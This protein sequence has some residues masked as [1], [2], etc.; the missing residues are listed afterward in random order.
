MLG[1]ELF[2]KIVLAVI[3]SGLIGLEREVKERPAG[4]RTHILVCLGAAL[5]TL[6]SV[7]YFPTTSDSAARII[8][9]IITG[10]GFLGA[11]TIINSDHHV[12]GLTTAAGVWVVAGLG[13]ILGL[14]YYYLALVSTAVIILILKMSNVEQ[15]LHKNR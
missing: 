14:G 9:G 10:I 1:P 4:L 7:D 6:V 2:L 15:L 13:I 11:G 5:L 3:F 12:S 8:S